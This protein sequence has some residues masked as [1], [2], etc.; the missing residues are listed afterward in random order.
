MLN[1]TGSCLLLVC[2][3]LITSALPAAAQQTLNISVGYFTPRGE[4]ARVPGDVLN[5]NRTFQVFDVNE[6]SGVSVGGEWLLPIGRFFEGSAGVSFT[7]R[8]VPTLYED[9]V[10]ADGTE[11]DSDMR[12]RIMPV[13]FTLRVLPLGSSSPVQPYFGAGIGVFNWRYSESG[14]FVDFDDNDTIFEDQFVASGN[15]TGAVALAGIRFVGDA[16][17]VGGEIRYHK[18]EADLDDRFAGSKIDL[19]GWVYNVTLGFRFK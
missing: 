16:V 8:T 17:S 11:I 12:L 13:A 2:T 7:R 4:D 5:E 6:F 3:A 18:A 14:E 19:G 15:R 9:Y 1:R 10:D